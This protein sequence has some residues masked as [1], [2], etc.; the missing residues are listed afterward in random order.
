MSVLFGQVVRG[1]SAGSR[2][3][4]VFGKILYNYSIAYL[5]VQQSKLSP[6]GAVD[7]S[8]HCFPSQRLRVSVHWVIHRTEG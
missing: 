5:S 8:M 2:V 1:L 3:F 6:Q 7:D 4:E